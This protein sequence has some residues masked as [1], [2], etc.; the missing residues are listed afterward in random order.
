MIPIPPEV[1][2]EAASWAKKGVVTIVAPT[3]WNELKKYFGKPHGSRVKRGAYQDHLIEMFGDKSCIVVDNHSGE[4]IFLT[5]DTI[6]RCRFIKKKKSLRNM[7]NYYYYNI[8][9]KDGNESYVKMRKKYRN[10][11]E[12]NGVYIS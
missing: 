8:T 9:F 1:L 7:K 3:A 6:Q 11:M 2:A 4:V 5:S 12:C 10:A